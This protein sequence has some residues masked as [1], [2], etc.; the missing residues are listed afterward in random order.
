MS[1]QEASLT[2]LAVR[3]RQE[4]ARLAHGADLDAARRRF[5]QEAASFSKPRVWWRP[6]AFLIAAAL[7]ATGIAAA[8]VGSTMLAKHRNA[9][10][11]RATSAVRPAAPAALVVSSVADEAQVAVERPAAASVD[12]SALP[13]KNPPPPVVDSSELHRSSVPL[14]VQRERLLATRNSS[15]GTAGGSAAAFRLGQLYA[16]LMGNPREAAVWFSTYLAEQP[17]GPLRGDARGRLLECLW[18][19][20]QKDSARQQAKRYL[21]E[22]P[23]GPYAPR[24]QHILGT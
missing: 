15:R 12:A 20:G 17:Q 6:R 2:E 9:A 24:A 14:S 22:Y 23:G 18:H 8:A 1:N 11:P 19:S 13:K 10:P 5:V 4:H 3:A 16:D 7:L 21:A